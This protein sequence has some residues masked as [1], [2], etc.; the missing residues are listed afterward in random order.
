HNALDQTF[1][2]RI[3]DELYLKRLIVGGFERVYEIAKDFRNEGI[4]RNH[5]PE[6]TMLEWYEAYADYRTVM[7]RSEAL[8]NCVAV[9]LN[10]RPV[11]ISGDEEIDLTPPWRRQT[12]REAIKAGSGID[13]VEYPTAEELI[14]VA[15]A[16][17]ADIPTGTVWPRVVD[18]L[19]KQFVRPF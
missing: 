14:A 18:E 1:Y 2:L 16:K 8:I 7:E 12:L 4:D 6:F 11:L 5:S 3:A 15:R 13:Y 19:L 9:A 17:G 10:D